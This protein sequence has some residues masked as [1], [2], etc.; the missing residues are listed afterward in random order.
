[1]E[2]TRTAAAVRHVAPVVGQVVLSDHA[3]AVPNLAGTGSTSGREKEPPPP[4]VAGVPRL[5]T[6]RSC[7]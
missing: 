3:S 1:M 2:R 7:A 4:V 6:P 5:G